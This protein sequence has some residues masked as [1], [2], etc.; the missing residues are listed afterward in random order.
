MKTGI[1]ILIIIAVGIGVYYYTKEPAEAPGNQ[2]PATAEENTE[3]QTETEEETTDQELAEETDAQETSTGTDAGMEFPTTDVDGEADVSV[4]ADGETR[5][6]DITGTNY[7]FDV[8]EM[9]VT[10]GDT[11]TVN[12]ESAEGF[13]DWVVDEFNAATEQVRP[14]TPTSVTF[15][16]D[17][18]GTFEYYCSVGSH[19]ELGMVGTLIVEP[20]E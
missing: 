9:R 12:F 1:L 5:T 10:E 20:A 3:Q 7:E 6:F 13:H 17:E 4:D 2:A 16:A 11:V 8:T 18:A 15:V 19:R 14:G